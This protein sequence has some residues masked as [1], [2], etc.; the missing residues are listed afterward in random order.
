[1][2]VLL[3][4]EDERVAAIERIAGAKDI[5]LPHLKY[6]NY[7]A[8]PGHQAVGP[9]PDCEF[10]ACGGELFKHQKVGVVWAYFARKGLLADDPGLGKTN[11]V[12]GLLAL[13]KERGELN[14]RALLIVQT[15]AVRQWIREARRWCPGVNFAGITG[16]LSKLERS[17][18]YAENWDALIIGFHV[19]LRDEF[20]LGK[21]GPFAFVMSDDVDPLLDHENKTHKMVVNLSEGAERSLTL[22]ATVL[23]VRLEQLHAAL[24]P[25]GGVR[26]FGSV[27]SFKRDYVRVE[28][29]TF[30]KSGRR[31]RVN[32]MVGYKNLNLLR[33]KLRGM[34]LRR[35]D[36][37]VDDIRMP[38]LAPP[39]MVWLELSARQKEAYAAL[40]RDALMLKRESGL[41]HAK[42]QAKFMYGQMICAGMP[43]LGEE[44]SIDASPKLDWILHH[45]T[46]VWKDRKV[47]VFMKNVGLVKAFEQ[48]C[49]K[50]GIGVAKVWGVK[51]NDLAR[52]QEQDRFW[53]DPK[54]RVLIGTTAVERSLN[55][56][57]ANIVVCV[58]THLNPA[59]MK[60]ILGRVKRAGSKFKTVYMFTLLMSDTQEEGYEKIL[61]QRQAL[62][63]AVFDEETGMYAKL[64]PMELLNL[65]TP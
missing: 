29:R 22:N 39:S 33:E 31:I 47:V 55:L 56:H 20:L 45:L 65:I 24:M 52:Q 18:V 35:R 25:S 46:T 57:V 50:A 48:R 44:D 15:P 3:T 28:R 38:V 62:N 5:Q 17:Q 43:A 34:V 12:L 53:N 8:C 13:L 11:T 4:E 41:T 37:D 63:D 16:D 1:M 51:Q 64:S 42:A 49:L 32:Q 30:I 21:L 59:R 19:A 6:W 40:Q 26:T 7:E 60:Q 23:Q 2:Q 27:K 14:N 61:S 9:Q 58:D 36:T 10:R 54:C